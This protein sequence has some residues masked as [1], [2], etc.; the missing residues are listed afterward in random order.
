MDPEG[1]ALLE[2]GRGLAGNTDRGGRRQVTLLSSERWD[3]LMAEVGASL[4]PQAR[5]ANLVVSGIDLENTRG[6]VPA[7]RQLPSA[8]QRRNAAV[9]VD[10]RSRGGSARGDGPSVGRGRVWRSPRRRQHCDR[11]RCRL[12]GVRS[13]FRFPPPSTFFFRLRL[14]TFYSSLFT[15]DFLERV[16]QRHLRLARRA[17]SDRAIQRTEHVAER[18]GLRVGKRRARRA[19]GQR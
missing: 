11:R 6:R 2:A 13:N 4:E 16:S 9:R 8:D 18:A 17:E 15:F 3:E 12:G 5:R 19:V 14:F 10:R 7:H 1:S